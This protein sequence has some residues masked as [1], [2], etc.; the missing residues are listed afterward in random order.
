MRKKKDNFFTLLMKGAR[1]SESI[2]INNR[3]KGFWKRN[4]R[5]IVCTLLSLIL[6]IITKSGFSN[7]F[8]SFISTVLSIFV[9]LFI[10]ALIFALDRFYEPINYGINEYNV[11]ITENE[12]H[13][14]LGLA[15]EQINLST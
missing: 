6:V 7:D 14:D 15:I 5:I 13:R 2:N 1:E 4:T 9:G 11:S 12:Q 8:V 3:K 10:T